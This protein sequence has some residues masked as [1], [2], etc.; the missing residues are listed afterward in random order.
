MNLA[1]LRTPRPGAVALVILLASPCL[2]AVEI[3]CGSFTVYQSNPHLTFVD[4][5]GDG[6]TPG[7]QRIIKADLVDEEGRAVG[8]QDIVATVV[9]PEENGSQ[10]VMS[11][12]LERFEQGSISTVTYA[13][14]QD[15][16]GNPSPPEHALV[17][18][19]VGGTDAFAGAEGSIRSTPSADGRRAYEHELTCED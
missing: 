8:R 17:W 12:I 4:H 15:I 7:D 13:K 10:T 1:G 18:H 3:Q 14:F 16:A 9:H 5:R 2:S 11:N 6:A 19:V